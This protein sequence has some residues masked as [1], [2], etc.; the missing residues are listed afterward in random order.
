VGCRRRPVSKSMQTGLSLICKTRS[1]V[2]LLPTPYVPHPRNPYPRPSG[3]SPREPGSMPRHCSTVAPTSSLPVMLAN[4]RLVCSNSISAYCPAWT[5]DLP[6]PSASVVRGYEKTGGGR[7]GVGRRFCLRKSD[8][9]VVCSASST[10]LGLPTSHSL[11]P[12]SRRSRPI[13]PMPPLNSAAAPKLHYYLAAK[14][15]SPGGIA[16]VGYRPGV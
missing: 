12:T 2:F 16:G 9:E 1:G 3:R 13:G 8:D 15:C 10:R 5:P 7:W 6:R 11:Q 4:Q 14:Q